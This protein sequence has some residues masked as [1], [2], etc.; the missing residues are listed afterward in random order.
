MTAIFPSR[1]QEELWRLVEVHGWP[2]YRR[3]QL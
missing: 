2:D 1:M 3:E